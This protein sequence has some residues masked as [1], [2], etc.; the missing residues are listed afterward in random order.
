M[1][2]RFLLV[3]LIV[4]LFSLCSGA[5]SIHTPVNRLAGLSVHQTTLTSPVAINRLVREAS[6][7][8]F[9]TLIVEIPGVTRSSPGKR[10]RQPSSDF[11][12]LQTL[13]T[14]AHRAN[15]RVYAWIQST[16]VTQAGTLPTSS[17]HF[18]RRHPEW[19][20]VPRNLATQIDRIDLNSPAYLGILD[21]WARQNPDEVNGLYLSPII[22]EAAS[23]VVEGLAEI[24]TR[25]PFD[26]VH[27]DS[28]QLPGSDF[29]YNSDVVALFRD[30]T[31]PSLTNEE[32][33]SLDARATID[34]LTYPDT[35]P[36]QWSRFRRSRVTAFVA[37]LSSI[38]RQYRPDALVSVSVVAN[39]DEALGRHLQDWLAWAEIGFVD[40]VCL[41]PG[42]EGPEDFEYQLRSAQRLAG[43]AEIWVGIGAR[44]LSPAETFSRIR[45]ARRF[46]PNKIMFW[47]YEDLIDPAQHPPGHLQQIGLALAA[48]PLR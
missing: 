45:I 17:S 10:V 11:D 32:Q 40:I 25:Y 14:V 39:P 26:G 8:D 9:T 12:G 37:R 3:S 46:S 18:I 22:P 19:L 36:R 24:L 13:L 16:L 5:T 1:S 47:S 27:L 29:D 2:C 28:V 48:L 21:R 7:S 42:F 41:Q 35:F 34:P 33:R 4:G 20:M 38:V 30:N 23:E 15:L 44:W 43:L 31:A 6:T